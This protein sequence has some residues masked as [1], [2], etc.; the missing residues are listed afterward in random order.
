MTDPEVTLIAEDVIELATPDAAAAQAL[1]QHL[2]ETGQWLD[3]VAGLACVAVRFDL[4]QMDLETATS[5]LCQTA[6][7]APESLPMATETLSIPAQYGGKDGPDLARICGDIGLSE[8]DFITRH[9]SQTYPVDMIGFTP[10]FAYLSGLG[11]F[12]SVGRL[13]T[14]RNRVAAGSIGIS[15]SYTGIYALAGPGGWPIIARTAH[16]LFNAKANDPFVLHPGLK[17][18]FVPV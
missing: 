11:P 2:R 16:P 1:A 7:S 12:L 6:A 9:S 8:A 3:V 18:R 17:I 15:A 5:H 10:G 13:E 4:D 14:P